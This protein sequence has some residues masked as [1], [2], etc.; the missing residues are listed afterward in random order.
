MRCAPYP[1]WVAL[2][3]LL[4]PSTGYRDGH[5]TSPHFVSC[6]SS[7]VSRFIA[8]GR[9]CVAITTT[10]VIVC[11]VVES[12]WSR[13]VTQWVSTGLNHACRSSRP[14]ASQ[15]HS[16]LSVIPLC[17]PVTTCRHRDRC[18]GEFTHHHLAERLC[19]VD[20]GGIVGGPKKKNGPARAARRVL[21]LPVVL[22]P[23]S[24][25]PSPC[26]SAFLAPR[27]RHAFKK[28]CV[29]IL[30]FMCFMLYFVALKIAQ[31]QGKLS[32]ICSPLGQSRDPAEF[33]AR[34]W[35]VP[36]ATIV[37]PKIALYPCRIRDV[38]LGR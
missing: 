17:A 30:Y 19:C 10:S 5:V 32:K 20:F 6:C 26:H 12:L 2:G 28:L 9:C 35:L 25:P 21:A 38:A 1:R 7:A 36:T 11:F 18:H 15:P 33:I 23:H 14:S 4:H 29:C 13:S 34:F 22:Y 27:P 8:G 37:S 3:R 16:R 24:Q 31:I